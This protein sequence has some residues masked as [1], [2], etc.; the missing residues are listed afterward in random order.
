MCGVVAAVTVCGFSWLLLTQHLMTRVYS[1]D[2]L[3]RLAADKFL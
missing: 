1:V 2:G 3:K